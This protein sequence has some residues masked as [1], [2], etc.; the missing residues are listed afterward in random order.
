M[1]HGITADNLDL[2]CYT[3]A[4]TLDR[5]S[6]V[7]VYFH[8]LNG[9]MEIISKPDVLSQYCTRNKIL[10]VY[11]YLNPWNWMNDDAVV[12]TDCIMDAV[13]EKFRLPS[14]FPIAITGTSMGGQ[15]ALIYCA[16][17]KHRAVAC[18]LNCPVCDMVYHYSE[19]ED[20]PRTIYSVYCSDP[21]GL[22]AAVRSVDP[23][24]RM[25]EMPRIPYFIAHCEADTKVN[26]QKHSLTYI[27]EMRELGYDVAFRAV[28]D[29]DHVD[30]TDEARYW[31]YDSMRDAIHAK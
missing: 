18:A 26:I 19:R 27:E 4:D 7:I 3:N 1:I 24:S 15:S 31:L 8:G 9:G 22:D 5:F 14:D 2:F 16:L 29:R 13:F 25:H 20:V 17:G 12:M 23:R 10:Y 21:R 11:P 30:L 6:G 28:A